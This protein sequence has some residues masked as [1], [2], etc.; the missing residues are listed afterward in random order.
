[1]LQEY[2]GFRDDVDRLRAEYREISNVVAMALENE[3]ILNTYYASKSLKAKI[4]EERLI[5]LAF[6]KAIEIKDTCFADNRDEIKRLQ[7]TRSY[8]KY[9][10][11]GGKE[12]KQQYAAEHKDERNQLIRE[13]YWFGGGKEK[14]REK[15][16]CE[17]CNVGIGKSDFAKHCKSL[18]HI[19]NS[20]ANVVVNIKV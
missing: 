8:E 17:C 4:V 1:M 14:K 15:H 20:A 7:R 3:G 9:L 13:K 2:E 10:E 19:N 11:N 18:K 6:N 16:I 5:K 12:K